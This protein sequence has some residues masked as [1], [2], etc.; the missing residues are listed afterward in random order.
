MTVTQG[1]DS[2]RLGLRTRRTRSGGSRI[3]FL[4]DIFASLCLALSRGRVLEVVFLW[5]RGSP[6]PESRFVSRAV[7]EIG[8]E[9]EIFTVTCW[10]AWQG[11]L[12]GGGPALGRAC[13]REGIG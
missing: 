13:E 4:L 11:W 10:W 6:S 7:L 3:G 1:L 9:L 5:Y 2:A 8:V 12:P